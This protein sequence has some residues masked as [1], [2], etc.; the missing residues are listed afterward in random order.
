MNAALVAG[1]A[2][3]VAGLLRPGLT[4]FDLRAADI[5]QVTGW[6]GADVRTGDLTD[7]DFTA[8]AVDGMDAVVHLAAN[9]HPG[10]TSPYLRGPNAHA[11]VTLLAAAERAGVRTVLRASSLHTVGGYVAEGMPA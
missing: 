10:A 3:G 11:V 1:A 7:P 4:G 8:A 9:P 6:D 2:G 5:R